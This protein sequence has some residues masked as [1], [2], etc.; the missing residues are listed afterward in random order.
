[1]SFSDDFVVLLHLG[2]PI[3]LLNQKHVAIF[4]VTNNQRFCKLPAI[5]LVWLALG[6]SQQL[7]SENSQLKT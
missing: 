6:W 2:A 3:V 5:T 7:V 1:L 4:F